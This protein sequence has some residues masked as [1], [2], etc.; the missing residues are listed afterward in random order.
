MATFV[1]AE[2]GN[3]LEETTLAAG[4]TVCESFQDKYEAHERI[5]KGAY[6]TVHRCTRKAD[7]KVFAVKNIDERPLKLRENF[8]PERLLREVNITKRLSH[9]NIIG[10]EETF[11]AKHYGSPP[12]FPDE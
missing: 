1:S 3:S 8:D 7:G 12:K 6:A 10:L 9:P 4:K 11:W 5:G 2:K